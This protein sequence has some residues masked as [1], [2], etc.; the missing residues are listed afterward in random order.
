MNEA[1][2]GGGGRILLIIVALTVLGLVGL[3]CLGVVTA[4]AVPAFLSYRAAATEQ[5]SLETRSLAHAVL[6]Q[7]VEQQQWLSCGSRAEAL[8]WLAADPGGPRAW[9]PAA[10]GGACWEQ[11]GWSPLIDDRG[12]Y[13]V[14]AGPTGFVAHG[15]A[16]LDGDGVFAEVTVDADL[17]EVRVSTD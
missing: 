5:L 1:G 10:L 11:L 15:I 3:F 6:G 4:I 12:G 9:D 8:A 16:D 2:G 17:V 7:Y 13:W 14:E